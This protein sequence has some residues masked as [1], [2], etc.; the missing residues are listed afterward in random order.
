MYMYVHR[1]TYV[2]NSQ[3]S[4]TNRLTHLLKV[5]SDDKGILRHNSGVSAGH[6]A[7]RFYTRQY[8]ANSIQIMWVLT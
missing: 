8:S 2:Y 6:S 4:V 7:S 1:L 5:K 3:I